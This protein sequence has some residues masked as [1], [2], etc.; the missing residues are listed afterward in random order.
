LL[1]SVKFFIG[2]FSLAK[3]AVMTRNGRKVCESAHSSR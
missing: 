3:S 2:P 1:T